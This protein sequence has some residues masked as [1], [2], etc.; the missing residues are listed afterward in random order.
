MIVLKERFL[1]KIALVSWCVCHIKPDLIKLCVCVA[2][3]Q[4]V[5]EVCEMSSVGQ[6][7]VGISLLQVCALVAGYGLMEPAAFVSL[8][9][10][11]SLFTGLQVL[12]STLHFFHYLTI[13]KMGSTLK[14]DEEAGMGSLNK[15]LLVAA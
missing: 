1:K 14:P 11:L 8:F 4:F 15:A 6:V 12:N 7:G 5:P 2:G 13:P 3:L 9:N 10:V